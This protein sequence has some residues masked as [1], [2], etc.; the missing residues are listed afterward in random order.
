LDAPQRFFPYVSI[1]TDHPQ[2]FHGH[3]APLIFTTFCK[4]QSVPEERVGNLME[5]D[6]GRETD[7]SPL[8]KV[9]NTIL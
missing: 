8:S 5:K 1:T 2:N 9:T 3:F 7:Y 6:G 4:N